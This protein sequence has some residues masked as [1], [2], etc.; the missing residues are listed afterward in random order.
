MRRTSDIDTARSMCVHAM[1]ELPNVSDFLWKG[2]VFL[3]DIFIEESSQ[4]MRPAKLRLPISHILV[5]DAHSHVSPV[6]HYLLCV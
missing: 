3:Q 4:Y 6:S 1:H 5:M 2:P